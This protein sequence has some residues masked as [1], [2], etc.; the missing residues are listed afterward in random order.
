ML[1]GLLRRWIRNDL[2]DLHQNDVR[3]RVIGERAGLPPDIAAL[4]DDAETVTQANRGLNLIVAFNYGAR[5]E[6]VEAA[7]SLAR[8]AAQGRLDPA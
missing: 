3:V 5:Q 6:I 7:R 8:E 2:A 4:L 1:M